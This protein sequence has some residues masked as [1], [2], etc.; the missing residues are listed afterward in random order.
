MNHLE[1][2][3]AASTR[4]AAPRVCAVV[5][6]FNRCELLRECLLALQ[7][8][9]RAVDEILV[10]D[11][12]STDGTLKMLQGEFP[13]V[14]VLALEENGGG[15]GG[16]HAGMEAAYDAGFEWL[17]LMDDDGRPA[18]DCLENMM[19]H[20]APHRVLLPMQQDE[21][22]RVYGITIGKR[23]VAHE[24]VA[25]DK[26]MR[27]KF[28]F[29]FVGP[30]IPKMV[31]EELG[32]PNKDFFIWLD[33]WEYAM[34]IQSRRDMEIVAV[35]DAIFFHQPGGAVKTV[36]F[37]GRQS[38]RVEQ[39]SWKIY[40]GTR[41]GLYILRRSNNGRLRK[42]REMLRFA[43]DESKL[44]LGDLVYEPERWQRARMRLMGAR[45]GALGRLGKRV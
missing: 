44:L 14:R 24:I 26:P 28:H 30:L 18:P 12:A 39:Q 19:C 13:Q 16:F 37:L 7:G 25:Q 34:R 29:T 1:T 4:A 8:Q 33:D 40:Y 15:A 45:D 6:T 20:A 2:E 17:W 10:V 9:T 43:L 11:N 27:G 32:L 41:N 23:N 35:P 38:I 5:V 3:T 31:V 21:L 42:R 36:T 22:G